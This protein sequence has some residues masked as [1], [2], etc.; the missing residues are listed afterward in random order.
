MAAK[1]AAALAMEREQFSANGCAVLA[2]GQI[3]LYSAPTFKTA[4]VEA[5]DAGA[6]EL[7]VDLTGVDFMDSTGLG[8]L[9]GVNKRLGQVGGAMA[10][11]AP[12]ETIRRTFEISGLDSAFDIY[13]RRGMTPFEQRG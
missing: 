12:D 11:V 10:I 3:D 5:I 7:I 2:H 6:T 8:V 1:D 4:L 13:E 9:I